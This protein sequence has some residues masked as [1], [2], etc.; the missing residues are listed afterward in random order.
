MSS[1]S[2]SWCSW[3]L[4]ICDT[5]LCDPQRSSPSGKIFFLLSFSLN[6]LSSM[7]FICNPPKTKGT[8]R[9]SSTAKV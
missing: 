8:G 2:E 5:I 1:P 3:K 9:V 6:L 7:F 4:T